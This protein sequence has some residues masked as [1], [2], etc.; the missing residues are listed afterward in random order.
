MKQGKWVSWKRE[1]GGIRIYDCVMFVQ[2][3]KNSELK[4]KIQGIAKRNKVKV[5]VVERAGLTMKKVL[6]RSDPYMKR[7]ERDDCPVCDMGKPGD[8]RTR[9]CGYQLT[10]KEDGR[11]Y[12]GQT[13]RSLYERVKEEIRDLGMEGEKSPLWRHAQLFHQGLGFDMEVKVIDKCFGKPSRQMI[14]E[15][16]MTER[17]KEDETMN[18]KHEWTYV[19]LNK[20]QVR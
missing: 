8:C 9:R 20:V 19:K 2:P 11:K 17:L 16:V 5:R 3:T 1:K 10:C 14:K 18:I 13:G 6:Q 4:R 12:R 15:A 7:C